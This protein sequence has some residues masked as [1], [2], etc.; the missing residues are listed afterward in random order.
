MCLRVASSWLTGPFL[1]VGMFPFSRISVMSVHNQPV[2]I[3]LTLQA[4][5]GIYS[6]TCSAHRDLATCLSL[7][8]PD[9]TERTVMVKED[10]FKLINRFYPIK[11]FFAKNSD[12]VASKSKIHKLKGSDQSEIEDEVEGATDV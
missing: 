2:V 9:V 4:G 6:H 11:D 5:T 12:I 10:S 7:T 1:S 8:P 3:W